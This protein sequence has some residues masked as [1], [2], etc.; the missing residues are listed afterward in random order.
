[1][2]KVIF[3]EFFN[4]I[5]CRVKF[6][7][8][9]SCAIYCAVFQKDYK[10]FLSTVLVKSLSS[11]NQGEGEGVKKGQLKVFLMEDSVHLIFSLIFGQLFEP[12]N[13]WTFT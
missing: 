2:L 7:F 5:I 1:M 3:H 12:S 11:K 10:K 6:F 9:I 4:V 8:I 13:G